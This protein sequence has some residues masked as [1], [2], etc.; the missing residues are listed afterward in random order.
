MV[1]ESYARSFCNGCSRS[2]DHEIVATRVVEDQEEDDGDGFQPFYWTDRYDMLQ[3]RGC[4]AVSL[5][6]IY[7]DASGDKRTLYFPPR[8]SR[9]PPTWR[10][11]LPVPLRD[12]LDEVY[13]ALHNDGRRLALMGLRTV[14]DMLMLDEVGDKG[15]FQSKLKQLEVAGVIASRG[16]E[17]LEIALDAG[18]AAAHRGYK[19]DGDALH[20]VMDIVENLLQSVY[21]LK[22][23]AVRVKK[24]TPQRGAP[25]AKKTKPPSP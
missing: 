2:T 11:G 8:V 12:V 17:V 7:E 5:R 13:V 1:D 23:V 10:W 25:A 14:V 20:A 15:S 19:P 6:D 9:R 22:K 18:N 21:H 4:G 3:C 16:R 24:K